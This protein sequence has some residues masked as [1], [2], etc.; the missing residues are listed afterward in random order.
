MDLKDAYKKGFIAG[1]AA[2]AHWKNG[3]QYVGT[4]GISLEEAINDVE[5]IYN[6][7]PPREE[8]D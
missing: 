4:T 3:E 6:F 5:S 2:F 1:M 7:Y 8:E